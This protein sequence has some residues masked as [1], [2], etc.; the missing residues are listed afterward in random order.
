MQVA[1]ETHNYRPGPIALC[2]YKHHTPIC[3]MGSEKFHLDTR[4]IADLREMKTYL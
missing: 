1:T 3:K 4:S 2:M